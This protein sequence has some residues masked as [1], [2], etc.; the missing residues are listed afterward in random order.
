[1]HRSLPAIIVPGATP[2][3][4]TVIHVPLI[5]V[6]TS[7]PYPAW[8]PLFGGWQ[9]RRHGHTTPLHPCELDE[10]RRG[11]AIPCGGPTHGVTRGR[12]L[13][14]FR[15]TAGAV[16]AFS[17]LLSDRLGQWSSRCDT[18]E[19]FLLQSAAPTVPLSAFRR[20]RVCSYSDLLSACYGLLDGEQ[21]LLQ[22]ALG[23][24]SGSSITP[25][26]SHG[27]PLGRL[28]VSPRLVLVSRVLP[29]TESA[30]TTQTP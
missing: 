5:P 12:P 17:G 20:R 28:T 10:E 25:M 8:S 22:T 30:R 19:P 15:V 14:H 11:L 1:M 13:D 21:S 4:S 18:E 24:R 27:F 2:I 23:R 29:A 16:L 26:R 9:C 6:G 3:L 7:I